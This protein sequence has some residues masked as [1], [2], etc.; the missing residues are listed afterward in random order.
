MWPSLLAVT[1]RLVGSLTFNFPT[2]HNNKSHSL[3]HFESVKRF[4]QSVNWP[5][6]LNHNTQVIMFGQNLLLHVL[7]IS[8]QILFVH[9]SED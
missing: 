7:K 6:D 4:A 8:L 9:G 3:Y 5:V 2:L 1:Q